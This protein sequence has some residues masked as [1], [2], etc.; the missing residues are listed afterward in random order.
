MRKLDQSVLDG[1]RNGDVNAIAE[2]IDIAKSEELSRKDIPRVWECATERILDKTSTNGVR[3][4]LISL[5]DVLR[6]LDHPQN[7]SCASLFF[8]AALPDY[9]EL[10]EKTI[11]TI[12]AVARLRGY[13]GETSE[14]FDTQKYLSL[15]KEALLSVLQKGNEENKI[16]AAEGLRYFEDDP[17][18][19]EALVEVMRNGEPPSVKEAVGQSLGHIRVDAEKADAIGDR[20]LLMFRYPDETSPQALYLEFIYNA[21]ETVV[22]N[23]K[24]PEK[25]EDY[26]IALRQ[27]VAFGT[28]PGPVNNMFD[29]EGRKTIGESVENA[30]LH[31]LTNCPKDMKNLREEAMKGLEAIASE[32]VEMILI[33]IAERY[34]EGSEVREAAVNTL[35]AIQK[36]R[37]GQ[38]LPPPLPPRAREQNKREKARATA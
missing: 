1:L 35:A 5:F 23:V 6:N 9:S 21:V 18:V 3:S 31:V 4:K 27:L 34:N 11:M 37:F 20:I 28:N 17:E 36:K 25:A 8:I 10:H 38:T 12:A 16:Y 7:E 29:D 14:G 30:L 13:R 33:K 26:R 19:K 24:N 32:R 15:A 2:V 22:D